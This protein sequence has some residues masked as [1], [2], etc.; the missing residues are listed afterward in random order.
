MEKKLAKWGF[1]NQKEQTLTIRDT[2]ER[3]KGNLKQNEQRPLI[4]LGHGDPSPYPSFRTTPVA[5]QALLSALHSAQF[6][7]YA[8]GAGLSAARR[9]VAEYLCEDLPYKLSK[10]DVFLTAGA[11]HAIEVILTVL[12]RPG[13]NILLPRPGYPL[14]EAR[15]AFSNLEVRHFD[16]L[17]DRGWEVDLDAVEA[18][19]DDNTIAM[20]VINP[21]NPCGN[22]FKSEHLQK[23]VEVAKRIGI[24]L[25]ADEVYNHLVFGCNK[26]VPMGSFG[27]VTPV[28]TLGTISKRWLIPGWRCGWI[29]VTDPNRILNK[30]GIADCIQSYLNITADPATLIQGALPEILG[31]S[32]KSFFSKT[33]DTLREAADTCYAKLTEIPSLACPHKPEGAMSTMV[34]INLQVLEDV[35]DDMDF[36]LKLASEESVLV[37]PGSVLGL[38]NWLRL[39]FT[40]E[41]AALRDGLERLKA[42][43]SRHSKK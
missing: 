39:S 25:I 43:C 42:F 21:G 16:L 4:H 26:F 22:V 12:A 7:G 1:K 2:L 11:N 30:T 18:L 10:E 27:S 20:V 31:K 13:A 14:Y 9:A 36:A 3:L 41:L 6:N 35:E 37:L 38:K 32:T 24:L 17:P 29:A 23:I 15:A 5:E 40:V 19:A 8:P 28:L 33:N 34:K